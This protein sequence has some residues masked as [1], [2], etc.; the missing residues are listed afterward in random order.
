LRWKVR[1]E[2]AHAAPVTFVSEG[3]AGF[4]HGVRF[5]G[6][7]AWVHVKRGVIQASQEHILRDPQN[8]YDTMPITLPVSNRHTYNFVAAVRKGTRPICDVETAV[9]SDTLCQLALI[10]VK[11]GHKLQWNRQAEQFVGDDAANA[12]LRPR[13]FR[14]DWKLPGV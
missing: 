7:S 3:T 9:R 13:T 11:Q 5:I 6:E 10:A 1:F 8:K 4:T 14:G 12:M 2:Y